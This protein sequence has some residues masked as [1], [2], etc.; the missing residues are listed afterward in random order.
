ML[1]ELLAVVARDDDEGPVEK[2]LLRQHVEEPADEVVGEPNLA[3]VQIPEH[4]QLV[5]RER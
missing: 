4:G 3:V 1:L 5:L 2:P